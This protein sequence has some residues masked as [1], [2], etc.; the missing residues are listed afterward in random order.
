MWQKSNTKQREKAEAFSPDLVPL[1]G[2]D[3]HFLPVGRK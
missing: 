1:T 3:L 2:L